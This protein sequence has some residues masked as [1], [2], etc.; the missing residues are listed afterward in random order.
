MQPKRLDLRIP[1][2]EAEV[3]KDPSSNELADAAPEVLQ[4][5]ELEHRLSGAP[6]GVVRYQCGCDLL[7]N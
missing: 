4:T 6:F 2:L 1:L 5:L 7:A 3:C